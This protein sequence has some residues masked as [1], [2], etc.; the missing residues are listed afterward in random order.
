MSVPHHPYEWQVPLHAVPIPRKKCHSA[1]N[2]QPLLSQ[3]RLMSKKDRSYIGCVQCDRVVVCEGERYSF[4]FLCIFENKWTDDLFWKRNSFYSHKQKNPT[5]IRIYRW[6]FF[7]KT[8]T[9]SQL[10][11]CK[12]KPN[13]F[14]RIEDVTICRMQWKIV[15]DRWDSFIVEL[16]DHGREN[17]KS[18]YEKLN[19]VSNR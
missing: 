13:E 4:R 16:I 9:A 19:L 6:I 7:K 1:K 17:W 14:D 15:L 3:Q 5:R 10:D 12:K 18:E 2:Q 8:S 11:I